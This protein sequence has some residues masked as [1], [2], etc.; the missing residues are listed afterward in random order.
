MDASDRRGPETHG[1]LRQMSRR[2]QRSQEWLEPRFLPG[3]LQ[4]ETLPA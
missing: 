4:L 3:V 1:L 2:W